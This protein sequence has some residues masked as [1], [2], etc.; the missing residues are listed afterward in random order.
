MSHNDKTF[1]TYDEQIAILASRGVDISTPQLKSYAKKALQH[2]GY[3]NIINGYKTLFLTNDDTGGINETAEDKF[4]PGTTIN[5]IIHLADFDKR[6]RSIFFNHILTVETNVK[7]LIAYIFSKNHGHDNYLI[8]SNFDIRKRDSNKNIT[9]VISEIQHQISSRVSDPCIAHYLKEYGYVPLW[10][11]NNILTLGTVSKFYKIMIQQERQ[12]VSR[13]FHIM[14][15]QLE[16]ILMYITPIRNFCA[17]NNRLY[18]YRTKNPLIDTA[19]HSALNIPRS[20]STKHEYLYGKRDLFAA[21]IALKP[22]LSDIEY[23][24]MIKEISNALNILRKGITVITEQDV[25]DSMGFPVTWKD[26]L[27]KLK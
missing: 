4:K 13:T 7:N 2:K 10:V 6:L 17:H 9:S 23:K 25:L 18:C 21:M 20:D 27:L 14:D 15:D 16:S 11:L 1:K 12:Y 26:D 8:Y 24:K 5:E 3:Y 22:V 19:T